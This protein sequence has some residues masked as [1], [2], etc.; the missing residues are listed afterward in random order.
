MINRAGL[1]CVDQASLIQLQAKIPDMIA[2]L[3]TEAKPHERRR[4][5]RV[6]VAL[7]GRYMLQDTREFPCQTIDMSPGGLALFAPVKGV[8]GERV[9]AYLDHLGR[10]EGIISRMFDDGFA[11]QTN[12][13]ALKREKLADQLTWLANRHA[14]GMKEDRRHE[15]IAPAN[16]STTL[17][18]A[19]GREY[20][21][22]L[23]DISISGAALTA[24]AELAM[25]AFVTIGTTQAKVVRVF[26]GGVAVEFS[27]PFVE[28][29]FGAESTL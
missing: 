11:M 28:E 18:I 16:P 3:Q 13:P 21:A 19:D 27:R 26:E 17:K 6:K 9:V 8:L 29:A 2:A 24:D 12:F 22:K 23:I 10:V 25:G 4:H 5:Q 1:G 7:L 14:L 20:R 15:R